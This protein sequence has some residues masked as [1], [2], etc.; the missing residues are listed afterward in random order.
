MKTEKKCLKNISWNGNTGFTT[1][2]TRSESFSLNFLEVENLH[3]HSWETY[4][5]FMRFNPFCLPKSR[6]Q[7]LEEEK[8]NVCRRAKNFK[9][10]LFS[11]A[12]QCQCYQK[13]LKHFSFRKTFAKWFSVK[14]VFSIKISSCH[15]S[16]VAFFRKWNQLWVI[17]RFLS[18]REGKKL[19]FWSQIM[20]PPTACMES[21]CKWK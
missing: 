14:M 11:N 5:I 17:V 20:Y 9:I 7:V 18:S 10:N 19:I 21:K 2:S 8:L 16:N 4:C 12:E 3:N 6:T 15:C 1:S 13:N